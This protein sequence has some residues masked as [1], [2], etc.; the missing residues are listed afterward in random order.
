MVQLPWYA[1]PLG[2]L[3][4]LWR[5]WTGRPD[6]GILAD[7]DGAREL[8]TITDVAERC[9]V[10]RQTVYNWIS[11]GRLHPVARYRYG[12]QWAPLF[13]PGDVAGMRDRRRRK[14]GT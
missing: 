1:P 9:H 6:A 2:R 13:E 14:T 12:D 11:E 7:V 4:H 3:A 8:L 5:R 10:S